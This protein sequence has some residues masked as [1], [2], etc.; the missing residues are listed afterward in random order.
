[1]LH[2]SAG[3][4]FARRRPDAGELNLR[5]A[6]TY[7]W[8]R[9]AVL[10]AS[11]LLVWGVPVWYR[12]AQARGWS[13]P[14]ALGVP[15]TLRLFGIEFLDPLAAASLL[16]AGKV[17]LALL[18]GALPVLLAMFWLG[19][20]FC[21]WMCPYLPLLAASHAL[22]HLLRRLGLQPPD[23]AIG[24]RLGLLLLGALLLATAISGSQLA[25]LV[26]PPSVI[27]REA[28]RFAFQGAFGS[29]MFFLAGVFL[30]DTFVSRAGFCRAICPGGALFS[31]L[32]RPSRLA[33]TRDI[34][35][36][37]DCTACDVICNL[38]QLPMIDRVDSGCER[39][40]K[41]IAVCPTDAL[42]FLSHPPRS[43]P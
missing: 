3:F 6:R 41:C 4:S 36:C 38:G 22:R 27:G 7:Q 23:V 9:R 26:Y 19:R 30:F 17:S 40:G 13:A 43:A 20:F 42:A 32:S 29:G 24:R 8:V 5:R 16:A 28:W 21:G 31:L 12:A 14:P 33:V 34:P 37:T 15:W 11:V 2:K 18:L 25:A 1:V 39:C 35:R 10:T